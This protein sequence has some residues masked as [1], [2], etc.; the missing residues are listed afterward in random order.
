M[1]Q[2]RLLGLIWDLQSGALPRHAV[3]VAATARARMLEPWL[4]SFSH[5]PGVYSEETE[6]PLSGIPVGIKDIIATAG[7]ATTNGSPIYAGNIPAEDAWI[8]AKIKDYGGTIFGKTVTTEFAWR[9]PGPTVNPWNRLHTPGGS[10]SGSAASVAAGIVPLALGTQTLGSIIR[11]AAYN[12][13]VG[14]K[15]S[16]GAIP[17]AGAHP[18]SGSLDHIGFFTR[19]AADAAASCALFIDQNPTAVKTEAVWADFFTPLFPR[20]LAVMRTGVWD[21]AHAGQQQNFEASLRKL[22]EAGADLVDMDLPA[23]TAVILE[24]A[25]CVL[26]Y[27]AARIYGDLVRLHPALASAPLKQLVADGLAVPQEKYLAARALQE[28]LRKD[29]TTWIDTCDAILTLPATGEAPAGLANTGDPVFCTPWTFMGAPTV[30]IPSGWSANRMP[31]GLQIV[32]AFGRDKDTLR[33]AAWAETILNWAAR[34]ID[35]AL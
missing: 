35:A 33:V 17:R 22:R 5:L 20:K 18:L 11:P 6:G 1:N 31:L 32:G 15:P 21:R 25:A 16:F 7:M 27:E 26:Q 12:G 30:T 3:T 28:R 4:K 24:A 19:S 29:L 2:N 13:V 23:D 9:H 8:V 14:Y 34:D 10:S